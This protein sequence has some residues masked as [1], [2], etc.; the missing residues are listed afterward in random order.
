MLMLH[1]MASMAG[2][3]P[4]ISGFAGQCF[5]HLS[6]MNVVG[7]EGIE[8]P[9]CEHSAFTARLLWPLGYLPERM[10]ILGVEPNSTRFDPVY[11]QSR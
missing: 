5:I 6:Y 2:V 9:K 4:A 3:E 1:R 7:R 8:P 11:L 10:D